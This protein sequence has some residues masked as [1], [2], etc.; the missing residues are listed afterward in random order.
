MLS[1]KPENLIS[2]EF[3]A[4]IFLQFGVQRASMAI[5]VIHRFKIQ[6]L[7]YLTTIFVQSAMAIP[8]RPIHSLVRYVLLFTAGFIYST[9][10]K[11]IQHPNF[12][13]EQIAF[14]ESE[15]RPLLKSQC[16]KCH[17]GIGSNGQVKVRSG[18][19][20]LSRRG[21]VI[22]G[23][24][25]PAFNDAARE[26]SA[27][28]EMV[29]YKDE[30][31]EMPPSGKLASDQLATLTQWVEMGLPWTADDIDL[32]VEVD[33]HAASTTEINEHTQSFWSYK[34]IAKPEPP[35]VEGAS[36]AIDAFVWDRLAREGL[37]HN[38][39]ASRE[40]LV[41]RA[42]YNLLGLPPTPEQVSAFVDDTSPD[43]WAKL[44][45]SLLESTHY[46]EHWARHWLDIVRYAE[47]NGFERDSTKKFIWRYRDYVIDAF[48]QD[49]PYDQFI[50]EQLAGD[51]LD[52][53]T[54]ASLIA[55]GYH[56]LMQWDDEPADRPQHVYD[57]LDD[58]VRVTTE[59]F[60]GITLGCARCHD[61]KIDPVSQKEY[62][63]FVSFF[64]GLTQHD[65]NRVIQPIAK[66][67]TPEV[68]AKRQQERER[69]IQG[70]E[71]QIEDLLRK[72]RKAIAE[73]EA[74][75]REFFSFAS[76]V[77]RDL[78]SDSRDKPQSWHYTTEKP[79]ED[80]FTV[81][82][83]PPNSWKQ[84]NAPF[85]DSHPRKSF[86]EWSGE[87]LW[88]QKSF[89]L[90]ELPGTL[91]LLVRHR[92]KVDIYLNGQQIQT[93]DGRSNGYQAYPLSKEGMATLQT[94]RNILSVHAKR[95][96]TK[97]VID[98][99]LRQSTTTQL[100]QVLTGKD[101]TKVIEEHQQ[102]RLKDAVRRRDDLHNKPIEENIRAM[103]V[104][105]RGS[106]PGELFVHIR[107]SVHAPGDKV[108]PAFPVI[109]GG[110]GDIA[111][112]KLGKDAK[113]SGRRKVLADW[114]ASKDNRR[115]ARV[116]VNR[117]WQHHFGTGIVA[118]P[119]DFGFLG[120]Q[121]THPALLDW[122]ATAFMEGE[123]KIKAMQKLIMTSQVY[124][125]ASSPNE[126]ALTKNP[127]NSLLWRFPMRRLTAEEIRDAMIHVTGKMNTRLGGESF[128]PVLDDAVLATSSTKAG[129]WGNSS[130]DDLERR[131]VYIHIKR[132]LKPPELESFD[133]A[134]TDAP[135]AMRFVTTVPTQALN[136][137]NSRFVNNQAAKLADRLRS[138][139]PDDVTSQVTLGL[140]L[141]LSREA[142]EQEVTLYEQL[143]ND[144]QENHQLDAEQALDRFCLVALNLNEFIY[145]D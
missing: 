119:S 51:E 70:V 43:A 137:L 72:A 83:R 12:S 31:H 113:S 56:R 122:L 3:W 116:M 123:W 71:R 46:G 112:P 114:I 75:T 91:E 89:S 90:T 49:I 115:T 110:S 100:L 106:D 20:M 63:Q 65:Q 104:Q 74:P 37:T 128:Y 99:A 25:G 108:Q 59:G 142:N 27:I 141:A 61:H 78:I 39:P 69:D 129:K 138:I 16:I 10:A 7:G 29:S 102:R 126:A 19:Q 127:D 55:T 85:G 68:M 143:I 40:V 117:L 53:V 36:H 9:A 96:D 131:S 111:I 107:G 22:G 42:Y 103:I 82:F 77:D 6:T 17:G 86:T 94:G 130:E 26:K 47:S 15:V 95:L 92:A 35:K 67:A 38:P 136:M 101:G 88:L 41:R 105:E 11:E 118:S 13:R 8:S 145:L 5:L 58:I 32:M 84:G 80:W 120:D 62:Y 87:N 135:C 1:S 79:S 57:V 14:F 121:P 52:K 34:P 23:D 66:K 4:V 30:H 124:Q 28:L 144:L 140:Q 93:V 33:D 139:A 21:I 132:S 97:A 45:D 2:L 60:L 109:L 134:D 44:I 125:M 50:R 24:H 64:K 73:S 133:F 76:N 48:N 18:L 81:G 98:I 54:P